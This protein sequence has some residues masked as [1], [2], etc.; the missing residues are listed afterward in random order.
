MTLWTGAG[1]QQSGRSGHD[2]TSKNP[3]TQEQVRAWLEA[4]C[5]KQ[6]IAVHLEDP[7]AL[8]QIGTL[9]GVTAGSFRGASAQET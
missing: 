8:R 5:A 2:M 1:G 4:S 9:L 3:L 6:G 7:Q